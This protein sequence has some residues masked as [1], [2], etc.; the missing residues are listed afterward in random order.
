MGS[1]ALNWFLTGCFGMGYLLRV[2][3]SGVT[4][5]LG[6][7]RF[8]RQGCPVMWRRVLWIG[9]CGWSFCWQPVLGVNTEFWWRV[10]ER[11]AP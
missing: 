5:R 4:V 1:S 2:G 3:M 7:E 9:L 8:L 6:I 11:P 10:I